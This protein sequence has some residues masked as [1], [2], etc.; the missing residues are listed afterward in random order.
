MPSAPRR[1]GSPSGWRSSPNRPR[2]SCYPSSCYPKQRA[3]RRTTRAP[4]PLTPHP[5]TPSPPH[6]LTLLALAAPLLLAWAWDAS[7][8]APSWWVLGAQAYGSLGSPAT[9]GLAWLH[10]ALRSL[11]P[12]L[13]V[14]MIGVPA[15]WRAGRGGAP[16]HGALLATVL[17]WLPAHALLGVQPWP[18][19]LLPL[20]PL[21][22]LWLATTLPP[23]AGRGIAP[24]VLLTASALLVPVLVPRLALEPH[25][26][27]WE[28][29][30]EMG[31]L[32][33]ALPNDAT[34]FY[35]DAG[36]PLAWY[37]ADARATLVW[38]G[39]GWQRLPALL[40]GASTGPRF[41]LARVGAVPAAARG[42]TVVARAGGFVLWQV[43]QGLA[44]IK[45]FYGIT[46]NCLSPRLTP[47]PPHP[48]TPSPSHPLTLSC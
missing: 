22:A 17:L 6:P 2:S 10:V 29:I 33:E 3:R 37:A 9:S 13:A 21:L 14:G 42:A 26:G 5:L 47:S 27:R 24:I 48:L 1:P 15:L 44:G 40:Q 28:G 31:A 41:L 23:R 19:Y 32:V 39:E 30:A 11:G 20:V 18:R 43:E 46:A 7:R 38:A 36:R 35:E 16:T 25:D 4:H 8:A 34:L 12:L 45:D